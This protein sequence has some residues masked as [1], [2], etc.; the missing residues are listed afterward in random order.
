MVTAVQPAPIAAYAAKELVDHVERATGVRLTIVSEE[1]VP[2][3]PAK[4][5]YVGA[6]QAARQAGIDPDGLPSEVDG[7]AHGRQ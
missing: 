4:R 5:V 2:E 7:A 1:A 6:T 3:Q